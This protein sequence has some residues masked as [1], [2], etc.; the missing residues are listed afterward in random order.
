M[1]NL[2]YFLYLYYEHFNGERN[3]KENIRS[4]KT[5]KLYFINTKAY[6]YKKI[7][8]KCE[9]CLKNE[10]LTKKKMNY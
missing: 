9:E 6:T 4:K 3:E 7:I 5:Q 8:R 1:Y 2:K 10:F